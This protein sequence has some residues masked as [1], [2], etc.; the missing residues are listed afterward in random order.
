MAERAQNF[1][2]RIPHFELPSR[3]KLAAGHRSQTIKR[4]TYVWG[5]W[6]NTWL[7]SFVTL[8]LF[9]R[10]RRRRRRPSLPVMR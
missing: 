4:A 1:S 9:S 6:V 2:C 3:A 8:C 7:A 10:C 5:K